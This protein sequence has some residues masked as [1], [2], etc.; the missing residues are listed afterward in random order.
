MEV[1]PPRISI[2]GRA[3]VVTGV[4]AASALTPTAAPTPEPTPF[5]WGRD[6]E[7]WHSVFGTDP[8]ADCPAT[9]PPGSARACAAVSAATA[10]GGG[11][12]PRAA[13]LWPS[14][15][16]RAACDDT[17][18]GGGGGDAAAWSSL[19]IDPATGAL[20]QLCGDGTGGAA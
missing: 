15:T 8:H 6:E 18:G 17:A 16:L 10:V 13:S 19:A 3:D 20:L 12:G 4:A 7:P 11:S 5:D 14:A 2:D 1:E 9:P